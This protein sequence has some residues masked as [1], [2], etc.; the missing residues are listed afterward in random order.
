[1]NDRP[2]LSDWPEPVQDMMSDEDFAM[3]MLEMVR[4]PEYYEGRARRMAAIRKFHD[5]FRNCP[6][7]PADSLTFTRN[8]ED[9]EE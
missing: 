9:N 7:L 4:A 2:E 3:I 1:M 6:G 5:L 8:D